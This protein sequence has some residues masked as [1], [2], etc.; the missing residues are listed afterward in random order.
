MPDLA[1]LELVGAPEELVQLLR[2][3]PVPPLDA[4][5]PHRPLTEWLEENLDLGIASPANSVAH[6]CAQSGVWLIANELDRCHQLCQDLKQN[7]AKY[8]HGIMH[9]REGDFW[10]AKYWMKQIGNHPVMEQLKARFPEYGN[11]QKFVDLC[12]QIV[13]KKKGDKA[14]AIEIQWTE[15]QLLLDHCWKQMSG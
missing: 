1:V 11:S 12:E 5:N 8:W 9:R 7:D 2:V 15:M 13:T 6:Q 4:G 14:K 3:V 10:N